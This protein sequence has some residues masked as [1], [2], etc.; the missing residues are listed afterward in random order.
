MSLDN[1]MPEIMQIDRRVLI[2]I[3]VVAMI[4]LVWSLVKRAVKTA[5]VFACLVV[6]AGV[7]VPVVARLQAN[8]SVKYDKNE[9]A[10][11]CKAGGEI[12]TFDLD[13]IKSSKNVS[14]VFEKNMTNTD[15]H[16]SYEKP[17]G[18]M[19]AETGS[20]A[21]RIPNY[22]AEVVK[23]YLDKVGLKYSIVTKTDSVKKSKLSQVVQAGRGPL[24]WNSLGTKSIDPVH[25]L[26]M[27]ET[28]R[29]LL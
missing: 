27:Q 2:G 22:M 13:E 23:K 11:V 9:N 7:S 17:D 16:L 20:S 25:S 29:M 8:N 12:M 10:L 4:L 28:S 5:A 15:I 21:F 3:V 14:I 19:V 18:L 6:I 24:L 26:S 1:V